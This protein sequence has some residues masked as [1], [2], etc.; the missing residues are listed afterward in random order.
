MVDSQKNQSALTR[1]DTMNYS[2]LMHHGTMNCSGLSRQAAVEGCALTR[3]GIMNHSGYD[4]DWTNQSS[5]IGWP[6]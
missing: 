3:Q 4:C 5:R 6:P 1:Q 2:G